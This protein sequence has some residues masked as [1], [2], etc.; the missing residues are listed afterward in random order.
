MK[1]HHQ[2]DICDLDKSGM[3]KHEINHEIPP[4]QAYTVYRDNMMPT[5][6]QR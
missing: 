2:L 3:V 6:F 1:H 4:L 5:N